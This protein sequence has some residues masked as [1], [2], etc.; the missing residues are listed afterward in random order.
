M[1][2]AATLPYNRRLLFLVI[3]DPMGVSMQHSMQRLQQTIHPK[4]VEQGSEFLRHSVRAIILDGEEIL[5]LYTARYDDYSLPGGGV[6]ADESI[7]DALI[8]EVEEET[9]ANNIRII[10]ELGLYEELRPWYKPEHDN[11]RMLS[12]CFICEADKTLGNTRLED[13]EQANGMRP[14]WVNIHK[15]IA[16][17]EQVMANSEKAGLS[18]QR[19]TWLL[20][21]VVSQLVAETQAA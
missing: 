1:P 8:R 2:F 9:G 10:S 3:S 13:Y 14:I 6:D 18:I 7:S 4:A 17:N 5:L 21:R 15:A 12:Y 19:E 16:H 20:K 11:V